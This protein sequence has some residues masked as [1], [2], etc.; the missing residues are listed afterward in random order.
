[1]TPRPSSHP[2]GSAP[3]GALTPRPRAPR[4]AIGR[5]RRDRPDSP[6]G[7]GVRV[8]ARPAA[9][10]YLPPLGNGTCLA[11][12]SAMYSCFHTYR[13]MSD[14]VSRRATGTSTVARTR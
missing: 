8:S 9:P 10:G 7:H 13:P 3:E 5:Q 6:D 4:Q 2:R 11:S 14:R 12:W 1:M